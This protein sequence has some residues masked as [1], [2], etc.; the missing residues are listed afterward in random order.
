MFFDESSKI[1]SKYL[2]FCVNRQRHIDTERTSTNIEPTSCL[3]TSPKI[4][5]FN[6]EMM[7]QEMMIYYLVHL[8]KHRTYLMPR[9][10]F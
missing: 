10:L 4:L 6:Q 5:D 8:N 1:E 9:Y 7:N 2:D 3:V